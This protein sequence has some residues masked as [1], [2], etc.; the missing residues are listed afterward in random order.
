[1]KNK[2]QAAILHLV[3][4]QHIHTQGELTR[5]LAQ[6]GFTATQATISRD[7]RELRLNKEVTS[8][9]PT[10]YATPREEDASPMARVL[11]TGLVSA[12]HAGH[13]LVLKTRIGMGMAVATAIDEMNHA[14]ILGTVAGDDTIICVIKT[15]AH[16]AHLKEIMEQLA[17]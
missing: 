14:E 4:T 12:N 16:A 9:G 6:A 1:M 8:S 10:R 17:Q 2:R 13:M 11:R 3:S 7:I 5:A 15:E